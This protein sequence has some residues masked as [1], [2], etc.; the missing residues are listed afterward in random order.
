MRF[1]VASFALALAGVAAAHT[2][3]GTRGNTPPGMSR[4]GSGPADGAI[5]GGSIKPGERAGVPDKS[6]TTRGIDRCN[7]LSGTMREQCLE[8][9][10]RAASG[11]SGVP[12]ASSRPTPP[13]TDSPPPQNPR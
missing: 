13:A 8:Q 12:D 5:V 2:G 4:D 6:P 9:E 7:E 11:G 1:L 3:D 10:K